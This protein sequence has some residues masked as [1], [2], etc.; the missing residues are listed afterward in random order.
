MYTTSCI[1]V[2]IKK[3]DDRGTYNTMDIHVFSNFID[4]NNLI[5]TEMYEHNHAV[6]IYQYN[7]INNNYTSVMYKCH[8][9][10]D[11]GRLADINT[12]SMFDDNFIFRMRMVFDMCETNVTLH[13][14]NL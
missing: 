11:F 12:Y 1:V 5:N 13:P 4:A 14:T 10:T 3:C 8:N 2:V 7:C 9:S 6:D